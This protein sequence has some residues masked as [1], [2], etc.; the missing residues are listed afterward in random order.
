MRIGRSSQ[1][2]RNRA[3]QTPMACVKCTELETIL[4]YLV[5]SS[6]DVL[7]PPRASSELD[8]ENPWLEGFLQKSNLLY[9]CN[10]M[11]WKNCIIFMGWNGLTRGRCLRSGA[12]PV[13]Y[14]CTAGAVWFRRRRRRWM[15]WRFAA[16]FGLFT[17]GQ[18]VPFCIAWSES[19]NIAQID[20]V[21]PFV[22]VMPSNGW[23]IDWA[24][25]MS[26][27]WGVSVDDGESTGELYS[28]IR[29]CCISWSFSG[30]LEA[31]IGFAAFPQ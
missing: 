8:D 27:A 23:C 24:V 17:H 5:W 12:G 13:F 14:R 9:T 31:W 7:L 21:F 15:C 4:S 20:F 18:L 19:S 6:P 28:I 30:H 11:A 29:V 2:E 1:K 22:I 16:D 25:E 26:I 10:F 3:R